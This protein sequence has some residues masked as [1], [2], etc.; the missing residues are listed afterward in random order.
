MTRSVNVT[1][2]TT[3]RSDKTESKVTRVMILLRL[4]IDGHNASRGPSATAE[5]LVLDERNQ[6]FFSQIG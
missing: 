4:T 5:L 1:P 2:K 3:L 6:H